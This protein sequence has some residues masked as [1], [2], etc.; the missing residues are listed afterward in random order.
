MDEKSTPTARF[1]KEDIKIV[2]DYNKTIRE[3][4]RSLHHDLLEEWAVSLVSF[5]KLDIDCC[6]VLFFKH[7]K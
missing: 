4:K 5:C 3:R 6:L 7:R 1:W 2:R